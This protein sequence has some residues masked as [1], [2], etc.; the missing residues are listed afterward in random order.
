[1]YK[2]VEVSHHT[3]GWSFIETNPSHYM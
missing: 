2:A 1:M 3:E